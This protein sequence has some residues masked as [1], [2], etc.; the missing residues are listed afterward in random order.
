MA[1]E[2]DKTAPI[3]Y[4]RAVRLG[5]EE[6]VEA[7]EAQ[8]ESTPVDEK[9]T[10][11]VWDESNGEYFPGRNLPSIFSNRVNIF[12]GRNGTARL[13]FGETIWGEEPAIRAAITMPMMDAYEMALAIKKLVEDRQ[14]EDAREAAVKDMING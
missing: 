13:A 11:F 4:T 1:D 14:E 2:K 3:A 12:L 7:K 8:G 5:V 6:P 10:S 9:A